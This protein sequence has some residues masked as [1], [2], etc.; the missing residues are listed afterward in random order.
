MDKQFFE[1]I[2]HLSVQDKKTLSQKALKVG[3]EFGELAKAALPYDNAHT[4]TH[5]FVE[6]EKILEE[7]IDTVLT[8]LSIPYALGFTDDEIE[9][10]FHRKAEKWAGLQAKEANLKYPLPFELHITVHT[11]EIDAFKDC[12]AQIG[13]KPIVID[14][15]T[16]AG[17]SVM[18][19]VMT[20]S[21]HFGD[22][23]S[24][25]EE[26]QRIKERLVFNG[27]DVV[28]VKIE[29]VPWHPAAPARPRDKMPQ[30]CY[31]ESHLAV[32]V[33]EDE[34][35]MLRKVCAGGVHGNVHVSQNVFK[36]TQDGKVVIMVTY[37]EYQYGYHVF[38]AAVEE[39]RKHLAES[40]DVAKPI[41]EFS[42]Y[43]TKVS[44]DASWLTNT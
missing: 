17:V 33:H 36:R 24:A 10:M 41:I 27:F 26:S 12:C 22:N 13:V 37:R 8:A 38:S 20:S 3:E 11:S 23:R 31:F 42:V 1:Y 39:I 6:R 5:R 28:R 40:F 4:T 34:V 18:H 35:N 16:T 9:Q 43:D 21:K 25:Y 7:S 32:S 30:D 2:R 29:T 19:D 15:Q 14:L 44:H